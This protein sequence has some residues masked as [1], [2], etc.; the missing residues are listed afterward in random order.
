MKQY[1]G[2]KLIN[3]K[4]MTRGEYNKYR[5]W[6]V[7]DNENPEDAGYLVE[8]QDSPTANTP[9]HAGY[10][11]WSPKDVFDKAYRQSDGMP[12]GLA[13]EALKR[14]FLVSRKG[15]NGKGMWLQLIKPLS[16]VHLAYIQMKTVDDTYV[17]W[18]ASQTDMLAD[19]WTIVE[20]RV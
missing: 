16:D 12:F 9:D 4:P 18:L 10:V 15:W 14:G 20:C 8:Y 1:I 6:E 17:P 3:A 5:G 7:P 13:I 19:D 2:T 11:S